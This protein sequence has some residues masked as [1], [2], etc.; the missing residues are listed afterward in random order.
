MITRTKTKAVVHDQNKKNKS[1]NEKYLE[2][3]TKQNMQLK[4]SAL[5]VAHE[6]AANDAQTGSGGG[7]T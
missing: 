1:T 3:K 5:A 2:S 7:D 6:A 4:P